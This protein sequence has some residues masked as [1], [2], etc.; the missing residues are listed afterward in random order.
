MASPSH[1]Y[2]ELLRRGMREHWDLSELDL[3]VVIGTLTED[4]WEVDESSRRLRKGELSGQV[5]GRDEPN[6]QSLGV[7]T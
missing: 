3:R 5:N 4:G 2:L 1:I 7:V 6:Q